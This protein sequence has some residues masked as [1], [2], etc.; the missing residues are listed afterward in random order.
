MP[1]VNKYFYF[2]SALIGTNSDWRSSAPIIRQHLCATFS[3]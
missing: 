3:P 1:V 2:L